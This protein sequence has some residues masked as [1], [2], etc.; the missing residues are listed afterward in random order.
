MMGVTKEDLPTLRAAVPGP[1]IVKKYKSH[2]KPS[3]FT[4]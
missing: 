3:L 1:G 2:I 4:I